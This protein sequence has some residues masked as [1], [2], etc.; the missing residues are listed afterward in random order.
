MKKNMTLG[1]AASILTLTLSVFP[2]H[3]AASTTAAAP[4]V[5]EVSKPTGG[6]PGPYLSVEL[7]A[8]ILLSALLP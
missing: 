3:A 8:D 2:H 5:P 4:T 7:A 1:L 6:K